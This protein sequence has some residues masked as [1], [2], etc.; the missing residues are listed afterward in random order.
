MREYDAE[1]QALA[2]LR[3]S[4]D[5]EL[6]ARLIREGKVIRTGDVRGATGASFVRDIDNRLQSKRQI[7]LAIRPKRKKRR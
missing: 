4:E 5:R 7:N 6:L 3:A 2:E 1:V